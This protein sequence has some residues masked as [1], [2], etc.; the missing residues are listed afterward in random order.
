MNMKPK[1]LGSFFH[2]DESIFLKG[3]TCFMNSSFYASGRHALA[4]ILLFALKN[5]TIRLFVP[6]YYCHEVTD[7]IAGIVPIEIY[8]CSPTSDRQAIILDDYEAIILVEYFGERSSVSVTGG[9]VLLDQTHD[10]FSCY[11]YKRTPDFTFGSLRKIAPLPDGGFVT[12]ALIQGESNQITPAAD[13][14][15]DQVLGMLNAMQQKANYLSGADIDKSE[16]L[17]AY[18]KFEAGIGGLPLS[19][20][21]STYSSRRVKHLDHVRLCGAKLQNLNA[22]KDCLASKKMPFTIMGFH[23]FAVLKFCNREIRDLYRSELTKLNVY[24]AILWPR[25]QYYLQ[26]AEFQATHIILHID[27]RVTRDV[28]YLSDCLVE[29]A[30]VLFKVETSR[31]G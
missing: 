18:E 24:S 21:I 1:E 9:K 27:Y 10:P 11:S 22:L 30:D 15:G 3:T 2:A 6:S 4:N 13:G 26:D 23:S 7:F 28:L 29:A 20:T 31:H 5:T 8:Q 19:T 14:M 17:K 16:Y 12:P 25:N